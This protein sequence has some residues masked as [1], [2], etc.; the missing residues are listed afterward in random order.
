MD[1]RKVAMS[2]IRIAKELVSEKKTAGL[3]NH[4]VLYNDIKDIDSK[5]IAEAKNIPSNYKDL[6][7]EVYG[8]DAMIYFDWKSPEDRKSGEQELKK[9]GHKVQFDYYPGSSTS[10]IQVKYFKGWHHDE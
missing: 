6:R 7:N 2:L 4:K 8:R 3:K 10:E 9:R 5:G 1:N